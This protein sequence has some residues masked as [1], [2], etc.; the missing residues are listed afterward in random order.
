MG[1]R[2]F[3][4][5]NAGRRAV[6]QGVEAASMGPRLFSRGNLLTLS[7]VGNSTPASMGPRLFS[8]GNLRN[9][10]KAL[11]KDLALQW[12]RDFQSRKCECDADGQHTGCG[13]SM[14]PRLFSRGNYG[15]KA[16]T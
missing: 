15:F 9:D 6:V 14:G 2:L 5:G 3:S 12:G 8:R 13:A 11:G 4:R 1:P 7:C 10:A 16:R